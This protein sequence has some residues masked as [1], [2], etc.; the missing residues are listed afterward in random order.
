MVVREPKPFRMWTEVGQLAQELRG[1][2]CRLGLGQLKVVDTLGGVAQDGKASG[3][4]KRAEDRAYEPGAIADEIL[5]L[6]DDHMPVSGKQLHGLRGG[7]D[8]ICRGTYSPI[9][10]SHH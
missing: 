2:E 1:R 3:G 9:E 5:N 10:A 4:V 8:Q 7:R 6:V